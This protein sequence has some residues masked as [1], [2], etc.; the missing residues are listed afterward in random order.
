MHGSTTSKKYMRNKIWSLISFLG[1]PFW[2]IMLS[3]A[4]IQHPLCVYY[5]GTQTEFRPTIIAPYDERMRSVCA[6]PVAGARFFH[7]MVETFITD[8]LGVDATHRGLYGDTAGYYGTVEQQGRLTLHL[9]MLLWIRGNINPQEMRDKILKNNSVWQKK[10][11][12]WLESCHTGD[13]LTGSYAE[14][15]ESVGKK[16]EEEG[17]V[18]P[19][20]LFPEAPPK[21]WGRV[22]NEEERS[23]S[24]VH[25]VKTL[26]NGLIGMLQVSMTSFCAPMSTAVIEA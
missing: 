8:V 10:L 21:K 19:T 24:N 12:D 14:V 6:N 16:R 13:F 4:D 5:A 20:Q 18:D 7:F 3:P 23:S 11:I 9:H 2:Y 26:L 17:Y 1:A 25:P 22:H 15:S